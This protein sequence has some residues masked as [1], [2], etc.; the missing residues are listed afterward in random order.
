MRAEAWDRAMARVREFGIDPDQVRRHLVRDRLD[1]AADLAE[2]QHEN[3]LRRP[4]LRRQELTDLRRRAEDLGLDPGDAQA[5]ELRRRIL[6][7]EAQRAAAATAAPELRALAGR[8][9]GIPLSA[10]ARQARRLG[11]EVSDNLVEQAIRDAIGSIEERGVR[12]IQELTGTRPGIP[13]R[14]GR[15]VPI[16]AERR[17]ELMRAYGIAPAGRPAADV[18]RELRA[19]IARRIAAAREHG[20]PVLAELDRYRVAAANESMRRGDAQ[21][22]AEHEILYQRTGLSDYGPRIIGYATVHLHYGDSHSRTVPGTRGEPDRLVGVGATD[23]PET[24]LPAARRRGLASRGFGDAVYYQVEID[25]NGRVWVGEHTPPPE[26]VQRFAPVGR[27]GDWTPAGDEQRFA[28]GRGK[29]RRTLRQL[30]YDVLRLTRSAD[31]NYAE[32]VKHAE[33][34]GIENPWRL[35]PRQLEIEVRA[36]IAAYRARS[37]ESWKR[38][39]VPPAELP[40]LVAERHRL[41]NE[42]Q[43]V[44]DVGDGLLQKLAEHENSH[45]R[46]RDLKTADAAVLAARQVLA[47]L[48]GV[49]IGS[50][51]RPVDPAHPRPEV[52]RLITLADGTTRLVVVSPAANPDHILDPATRRSLATEFLFQQV[53]IDARGRVWLTDLREPVGG[54]AQLAAPS[55]LEPSAPETT[56]TPE[57]PQPV[58]PA[59]PSTELV[60]VAGTPEAAQRRLDELV[61]EQAKKIAAQEYWRNKLEGRTE[62]FGGIDVSQGAW[63]ETIRR[64]G[65]ELTGYTGEYQGL[66]YVS[67]SQPEQ[68][69]DAELARRQDPLFKL[70]EAAKNYYELTDEIRQL[71]QDIAALVAQGAKHDA[72]RQ[73]AVGGLLGKLADRHKA[74]VDAA[75]P[76]RLWRDELEARLVDARR[77]GDPAAD[78][79]ARIQ[80]LADAEEAVAKADNEID[81]YNDQRASATGAFADA[82]AAHW[83]SDAPD[84]DQKRLRQVNANVWF[85]RGV[86][87]GR[88][89]FRGGRIIV[90]AGRDEYGSPPGAAHAAAL[91]EVLSRR[92]YLA[93]LLERPDTRVDYVRVTADAQGNTRVE[94]LPSPVVERQ[95]I[96]PR[97]A[98]PRVALEISDPIAWRRLIR[99]A[100]GVP[101]GSDTRWQWPQDDRLA[102]QL[103]TFTRHPRSSDVL[104]RWFDADGVP[105]STRQGEAQGYR[106]LKPEIK[107]GTK[108]KKYWPTALKDWSLPAKG[109]APHGGEDRPGVRARNYD[110]KMPDGFSGAVAVEPFQNMVEP[111]LIHEIYGYW[112]EMSYEEILS[113]SE[114]GRAEA[115]WLQGPGPGVQAPHGWDDD[116]HHDLPLHDALYNVGKRWIQIAEGVRKLPWIIKHFHKNPELGSRRRNL[117]W[118]PDGPFDPDHPVLRKIPIV[119][120]FRGYRGWKAPRLDLQPGHLSWSE[121][122]HGPDSEL[123]PLQAYWRRGAERWAHVQA[124][125]NRVIG[126]FVADTAHSDVRAIVDQLTGAR[127]PL[128]RP[129]DGGAVYAELLGFARRADGTMISREELTAQ[130]LLIKKHLMINKMRVQ[131]PTSPDGRLIEKPYDRL[132]H[133]ADAWLRLTGIGDL[134]GR[135]RPH[136][137]DLL[138]LEDA[139]AEADFLRAHEKATWYEADEHAASLGHDWD[140]NRRRLSGQLVRRRGRLYYPHELPAGRPL[141]RRT[142]PFTDKRIPLLSDRTLPVAAL[143]YAVEP[144]TTGDDWLPPRTRQA[145]RIL[146]ETG[147]RE[148]F[149]QLPQEPVAAL[150][151]LTTRALFGDLSSLLGTDPALKVAVRAGTVE[152]YADADTPQ[153]RDFWADMLGR[154]DTGR[155]A[156]ELVADLRAE[157]SEQLHAFTDPAWAA[158]RE[159]EAAHEQALLAWARADVEQAIARQEVLDRAAGLPVDTGEVLSEPMRDPMALTDLLAEV[160]NFRRI[161]S[162]ETTAFQARVSELHSAAEDYHRVAA[163]AQEL[164]EQVRAARAAAQPGD[165]VHDPAARRAEIGW[166][167]EE[168]R[169]EITAREA[170]RSDLLA[171]QVGVRVNVEDLLDDELKQDSQRQRLFEAVGNRT[172]PVAEGREYADR[173]NL[174]EDAVQ[175]Y[176]LADIRVAEL[177]EELHQARSRDMELSAAEAAA[178]RAAADDEGPESGSAPALPAGPRPGGGAPQA[179]TAL[180]VESMGTVAYR[181]RFS[182]G[183]WDPVL[184]GLSV[185]ERAVLGEFLAGRGSGLSPEVS[186]V[187]D[188]V[189]GRAPLSQPTLVSFEGEHGLFGDAAPGSVHEIPGFLQGFLGRMSARPEAGYHLEL[190]VPEGTPALF[191]GGADL[192]PAGRLES[193]RLLLGRGLSIRV[194]AVH[195]ED[196]QIRVRGTVIPQDAGRGTVVAAQPDTDYPREIARARAAQRTAYDRLEL[197]RR[198]LGL[199]PDL[200]DN[201]VARAVVRAVGVEWERLR[202]ETRAAGKSGDTELQR[203]LRTQV[204]GYGPVKN[205]V[206]QSTDDYWGAQSSEDRLRAEARALGL[207]PSGGTVASAEPGIEPGGDSTIAPSGDPAAES[208]RDPGAGGLSEGDESGSGQSG[209][210]SAAAP[211]NSAV[212]T[213]ERNPVPT[214]AEQIRRLGDDIADQ[215]E[216]TP[217]QGIGPRPARQNLS[218]SEARSWS[219]LVDRLS[220]GDSLNPTGHT[221]PVDDVWSGLDRQGIAAEFTARHPGDPSRGRP[222]L[223]LNGFEDPQVDLDTLREFARAVDGI[224]TR[225]PGIDLHRVEIT[226]IAN[227]D[228][229][230]TVWRKRGDGS[231]YAETIRLNRD[232]ATHPEALRAAMRRAEDDG[233]APP[234]AAARPVFARVVH[235]LGHALD[236]AG[237]MRARAGA[238]EALLRHYKATRGHID[239][240][241][242]LAWVRGLSAYAFDRGALRPGDALADAFLDVV[243]NGQDAA[244]PAW[245]LYDLLVRTAV[246]GAADPPGVGRSET[247]SAA[248]RFG[249]D[250]AAAPPGASAHDGEPR[251]ASPGQQVQMTH[252]VRWAAYGGPEQPDNWVAHVPDRGLVQVWE[253]LSHTEV[254]HRAIGILRSTGASV[255]LAEPGDRAEP[256]DSFD[257]RALDVVI[258]PA[259]RDQVTQAMAVVR[260]TV[261]IEAVQAGTVEVMPTRIAA[262]DRAEH[263]AAHRQV[264][265]DAFVTESE[266]LRELRDAGVD[267]TPLTQRRDG[268]EYAP[269]LRSVYLDA[270]DAAVTAAPADQPDLRLPGLEEIGREAGL[271]ALLADPV[272]GLEM[273]GR[274]DDEAD[275]EWEAARRPALPAQDGELPEHIPATPESE[276]RLRE[277]LREHAVIARQLREVEA[278]F[279]RV[280]K[281]LLHGYELPDHRNPVTVADR[282]VQIIGH[283][284]NGMYFVGANKQADTW[285]AAE[286]AQ[287]HERLRK[288]LQLRVD[289]I[290][291]QVAQ[292]MVAR[293]GIAWPSGVESRNLVQVVVDDSGVVHAAPNPDPKPT[294]SA[295]EPMRIDSPEPAAASPLAE[296]SR[297]LT[298]PAPW[299]DAGVLVRKLRNAGGGTAIGEWTAAVLQR[300]R[301]Q[302]RFSTEP[303]VREWGGPPEPY[304][305]RGIGYDP[306]SRTVV[307]EQSQLPARWLSELIRAA[308]QIDRHPPG[309]IPERLT[310]YRDEYIARMLDTEAQGHALDYENRRRVREDKLSRVDPLDRV[311]TGRRTK[312]SPANPNYLSTAEPHERTYLRVYTEALAGATAE[313]GSAAAHPEVLEAAAF[314]AGVR[315]IRADIDSA[316]YGSRADGG[317]PAWRYGAEW[318]RAHGVAV[319]RET[320]DARPPSDTPELRELRSAD[321]AMEIAG[322][323]LLR[324]SGKAIPVGPAERA[325]TE[326]YDKAHAKAARAAR[327][328]PEAPEHLAHE[329]G[330]NA[331][332]R[333]VD[334]VGAEQAELFF[335]V[336]RAA[337]AGGGL[338]WGSPYVEAEPD[339]VEDPA[340]AAESA[341]ESPEVRDAARREIDRLMAHD[342]PH[343]TI[344]RLTDTVA[345]IWDATTDDERPALVVVAGPGGHLDALGELRDARPE[346]ADAWWNETHRMDYRVVEPDQDGT[347]QVRSIYAEVAEGAYRRPDS[348]ESRAQILANYLRHRA[349]GEIRI[350]FDEWL[351]QLGPTVIDSGVMEIQLGQKRKT[352]VD[353]GERLRTDFVYRG[354]QLARA[355]PS[356]EP[357]HPAAVLRDLTMRRVALAPEGMHPDRDPL[358]YVRHE[359]KVGLMP[360]EVWLE[361]D[362]TGGWRVPVLG[363]RGDMS[364]VLSRYLQGMTDRDPQRLLDRISSTLRNGKAALA[365]EQRGMFRRAG[366]KFRRDAGPDA[367]RGSDGFPLPGPREDP[368]QPEP[369]PAHE[370]VV[371]HWSELDRDGIVAELT[372]RHPGDATLG[373]SPLEVAG[374]DDPAV[375]LDVL[376]EYARAI[377]DILPPHPEIDVHRI[378]IGPTLDGRP[379]QAVWRKR[380]DG[381]Y[382]A[383]SITLNRDLALHPEELRAALNRAERDRSAPRGVGIRPV[384]ATIV[385]ELG[386]ALD[387]AGS[388]RARD[389]AVR[390]L[391]SHY[392]TARGAVDLAGYLSWLDQLSGDSFD[393]DTL[394]PKEALA[395]AFLDVTLNGSNATEPARV[396]YDL[397]L[398]EAG[399]PIRAARPGSEAAA[400]QGEANSTGR[401][402]LAVEGNSAGQQLPERVG[403]PAAQQ[404]REQAAESTAQGQ[405]LG[406]DT[407]SVDPGGAGQVA[408]TAHPLAQL[409]PQLPYELNAARAEVERLARERAELTARLPRLNAAVAAGGVDVEAATAERNTLREQILRLTD[410][411]TRAAGPDYLT[412]RGAQVT[413]EHPQVGLVS[414]PPRIIVVGR[415]F[416]EAGGSPHDGILRA[417]LPHVPGLADALANPD[418]TLEY[419]RLAVDSGGRAHT[420]PLKSPSAAQFVLEPS[421]AQQQSRQTPTGQRASGPPAGPAPDGGDS[422]GDDEIRKPHLPLVPRYYPQYEYNWP[423]FQAA[424]PGPLPEPTLPSPPVQHPKPPVQQPP[425]PVQLPQPPVQQPQPPGRQ[426]AAPEQPHESHQHQHEKGRDR[427]DHGRRDREHDR[428]RHHDHGRHDHGHDDHNQHDHGHLHDHD[429][430]DRDQHDHDRDGDSPHDRD[431]W[432]GHERDRRDRDADDRNQHDRDRQHDHDDRHQRGR[433]SD[434]GNRRDRDHRHDHDDHDGHDRDQYN[435]GG[436]EDRDVDR[437]GRDLLGEQSVSRRQDGSG[438]SDSQTADQYPSSGQST[439]SPAESPALQQIPFLPDLPQIPGAPNPAGRQPQAPSGPQSGRQ[440]S[441]GYDNRQ[442]GPGAQAPNATT[443][444][445]WNGPSTALPGYPTTSEPRHSFGRPGAPQDHPTHADGSPGLPVPQ[446]SSPPSGYPPMY[447]PRTTAAQN[448][449]Q[450]RLRPPP[451]APTTLFVLRYGSRDEWAELDPPTGA[452]RPAPMPVGMPSGVFGDIEGIHVVF[453]RQQG[454]LMLRLGT[455]VIDA[456]DLAVIVHWERTGRHHSVLTVTHGGSRIGQIRYR[457]LTPA[458]DLGLM[459][460]DVL[461]NTMRRSQF[462]PG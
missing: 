334:R 401:Q 17:D 89:G 345:Q 150:R 288:D 274:V 437:R 446:T 142:F 258:D 106:A 282:A 166:L 265:A 232:F 267:I 130:I 259:G 45:L 125:A 280:Y 129:G 353:V 46:P 461:D 382:Y 40:A 395:H 231:Y 261:R 176:H 451:P 367:N 124:W 371:D 397:L 412:S 55:A 271:Q 234:G 373:R 278:A 149:P 368:S 417:A 413:S 321:Y 152:F 203:E 154:A 134:D 29:A 350:G 61:G 297:T 385:H 449:P 420:A 304:F 399:S 32:L 118:L 238:E 2:Q 33:N 310:R 247:D 42:A 66:D 230:Q 256:A 16:T 92:H 213:A 128:L 139:H 388:M 204:N 312:S 170:A 404:R 305:R 163:R 102:A 180:G 226:P 155:T 221:A 4:D 362:G 365:P 328:S 157:V 47:G 325:Y 218:R 78:D 201:D 77:N 295:S 240:D 116:T 292:D 190:T 161:V 409:G 348:S 456:D 21:A 215:A 194:D 423:E 15:L 209:I 452:M 27:P 439:G 300:H 85:D 430:D 140:S 5:P 123:G 91:L 422:G 429:R 69:G 285:L 52:A 372:A 279:D 296:L 428:D 19:E 24:H 104:V 269:G 344:V 398:R 341:H 109:W 68:I 145:A 239:P 37:D 410:R 206:V 329:A 381:T 283:R 65:G 51:G 43:Q 202:A 112:P 10:L 252:D 330:R 380:P 62:K 13:G 396:L 160:R 195:D 147:L 80:E 333:H 133:V 95:R 114:Q 25:D 181:L 426:P 151:E 377:D 319:G 335:D 167:S 320:F 246:P 31:K 455:Q 339:P 217:P 298:H 294:W 120:S 38:T 58:E 352:K 210:D 394:S 438:D 447:P 266:L 448:T 229:A 179:I 255:R 386:H 191:V 117:Y 323:R 131:D 9:D 20:V 369:A 233:F 443:S 355:D 3:D 73:E 72:A 432:H 143:H 186:T 159:R 366:D 287:R 96:G 414:D 196:G 144:I 35:S 178:A 241:E 101:M 308:V 346:L 254:G 249:I 251:I 183:V 357:P 75:K 99:E 343:K 309:R 277:L 87:D 227:G 136:A 198:A 384:Y 81:R 138:L 400:A 347:L 177:T 316:G 374:F 415:R 49:P 7:A 192:S 302:V 445:G 88:G 199:D 110:E 57:A 135:T 103:E 317:L 153:E 318:D 405:Q 208:A 459:I 337:A 431:H 184:D 462:F 12:T 359:F 275:A 434:N 379:A 393:R 197:A 389:R 50:D 416:D 205:A 105:H 306:A 281:R 171:R 273:M 363:P 340:D 8:I 6:T 419:V 332:R 82:A 54:P 453:Y 248:D 311:V 84:P 272:F 290:G 164:F 189:L 122:E 441:P 354:Y 207:D 162:P 270:H 148:R 427:D 175:R 284:S 408:A 364:D 53:R 79:P 228:H 315:A 211:L 94:R 424:Q 64:L 212:T 107:P 200:S 303:Q 48:G 460:R 421:G 243:L 349:A 18:E 260:A 83:R 168:L 219:S 158:R 119:R 454:R 108:L 390:V 172:L 185:Q 356:I 392:T 132:P 70:A 378:D 214:P 113:L 223:R 436:Q 307:L 433:D 173:V 44:Q 425:R 314:R 268:A 56:P 97:G 137:E 370:P 257:A 187:L 22:A 250:S 406:E 216:K 276:Q 338:Q 358:Q 126:G 93:R 286:L 111:W 165:A 391:L 444:P 98:G 224:L 289:G 411:I 351:K 174:L 418:T 90:V 291:S 100:T 442:P 30:A 331:V 236:Y 458:I 336:I 156:H 169:R 387:Y 71:D 76:L 293:D 36:T 60:P 327:R 342:V 326:A 23:D 26:P 225:H 115:F 244:E 253:L 14:P 141:R 407:E 450:R 263:V 222:P 41:E 1:A 220:E 74:A 237:G 322:L 11:V 242:Y 440:Q 245:V 375:D 402:Q 457:N 34:F 360:L 383:E 59:A 146:A 182:H 435:G 86:P 28:L 403:E 262:L 301:V 299:Q 39:G 121:A 67:Q 376:R 264:E 361:R 188:V 127:D 313:Y 324:R 63:A 193:P 235:E